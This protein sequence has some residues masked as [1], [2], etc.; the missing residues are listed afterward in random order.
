[1]RLAIWVVML[2]GL[3]YAGYW[4]WWNVN[5]IRW[6]PNSTLLWYHESE[7][8]RA[9]REVLRRC[10]AGGFSNAELREIFDSAY[11]VTAD[12]PP[13]FPTQTPMRITV[14]ITQRGALKPI[15]SAVGS[16]A[17]SLDTWSVSVGGQTF[18][19]GNDSRGFVQSWG[20]SEVSFDIPPCPPAST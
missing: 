5:W 8:D 7:S 10:A 1:M 18:E 9:R 16:M 2:A 19:V 3:S 14:L 20:W 15:V 13:E 4:S 6:L 11:E 12:Y 17:P